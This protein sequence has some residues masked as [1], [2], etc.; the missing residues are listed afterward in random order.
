MEWDA[1]GKVVTNLGTQKGEERMGT[2]RVMDQRGDTKIIWDPTKQDEVDVAKETF[3]KLKKK[4][5]VAYGVKKGGEK[6][7]IVQEFDP[8]AEKIILAPRMV[9]G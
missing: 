5:Y 8:Q 2:L 4:G 1:L 9:G 7:E 3:T 6:G